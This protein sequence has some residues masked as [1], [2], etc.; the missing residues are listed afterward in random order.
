MLNKIIK[1]SL[2]LLVFL[3]PVFFLPISFEGYGFNKQYLLFFLVSLAFI[4]WLA[5][6]VICDK[7]IK[8]RRTP[9]DIP[10]LAFL[11]I[12]VL[13]TVFSIDKT[14][15]L[16]GFYGRFSDNLIGILSLG[17]LYFLITNNTRINTDKKQMNTDTRIRES[18]EISYKSVSI[19]GIVKVFLWSVFFVILFS[20]FSIFGVWQLLNQYLSKLI[21]GFQLPPMMLSRIFNPI[22]GS[23]EALAMFLAVVTVLLVGLLLQAKSE[24]RKTKNFLLGLLLLGS[25]VLLMMIDF[26]AAWVVL[27]LTLLLFLAFAFWSRI[28][29]ERVNILLIP[30]ILIIISIAFLFV[31]VI[32]YRLEVKGFNVFNPPKEIL[33]D[34]GTTWKVTFGAIKSYPVLG[35][36]LGTFSQDFAKFK[37]KEFNQTN[38][39]QIRFDKGGSQVAETISTMGVLGF[40]SWLVIIGLFLIISWFSLQAKIARRKTQSG[41]E[42]LPINN[43]Q[44]TLFFTFLALFLSQFVYYQNTVLSFTSWLIIGLSVVSWQKPQTIASGEL[45]GK[46][47]SEKKISFKDFPE[48]S[49]VFNIV[50]IVILLVILGSW[51]FAG[52]FYL[53]DTK[54]KEGVLLGKVGEL[55]KAVNLNKSRATYRIALSRAYFVEASQEL[56][57][58]PEE[59]NASRI[60]I[61]FAKAID[62]ARKVSQISPNWVVTFE[63]L[64]MVYRDIRGFAQGASQWAVNSFS[65]ANQLEPTNPVF[66]TEIGKLLRDDKKIEE[67]KKE[68][69][70]ALELK[71]DYLDAKIQLALI[72]ETQ[73]NFSE[74][75]SKLKEIVEQNPL[76]IEAIFQLGRVYY[77][78]DQIDEA[79]S[80]FQLALSIFPNHSNSLYALGL[81]YQKKGEKS[82]ALEMFGKVLELNPGN[83]DVIQKIAELKKVEEKKK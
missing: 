42:K 36:G 77:N 65:K 82:K 30:I 80:Q 25:I 2:Y 78:N 76:N 3:I 41:E 5:K 44:L 13:S 31:Q 60:Q 12:S 14:S 46:P 79:I 7:E 75:I 29:R 9:L 35:S 51:F 64:G 10:I 37:P 39:W 50:L 20:Y 68:F 62:E 22:G 45:R 56:Q 59:Q 54:Y 6:M 74:A 43:F 40:L 19:S 48:M 71:S 66:P 28:F 1:F 18:V 38:L 57:K 21:A 24:K 69:E 58:S 63:N 17:I 52:R 47:I 61:N 8:F 23:L 55:E 70:R 53:A 11:F 67:A 27:G 81:A 73:G 33:L 72:F 15:S 4:S 34:Q 83:S 49:L 32:N 16:F 26:T